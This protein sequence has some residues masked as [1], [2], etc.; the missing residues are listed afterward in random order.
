MVN[1]TE[2]SSKEANEKR[3]TIDTKNQD[4]L[5]VFR[6]EKQLKELGEKLLELMLLRRSEK[7]TKCVSAA[8]EELTAAKHKLMLLI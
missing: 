4:D 1:E 7:N 6:T 2:K 8:S 5:V 3:D